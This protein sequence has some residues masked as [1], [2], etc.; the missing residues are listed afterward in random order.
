[1]PSQGRAALNRR[2]LEQG[3]DPLPANAR[4]DKLSVI[5]FPFAN[6]QKVRHLALR[7]KGTFAIVKDETEIVGAIVRCLS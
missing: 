3:R 4:F 2:R 6:D 5:G 1:L 7:G